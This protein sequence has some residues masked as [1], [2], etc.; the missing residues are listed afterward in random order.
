[1]SEYKD[2]L[3]MS[4]YLASDGITRGD[5]LAA[6]RTAAHFKAKQEAAEK[7]STDAQRFGTAVHMRVLEP[8]LWESTYA[9]G[10][11]D[12]RRNTKV[13]KSFLEELGDGVEAMKPKEVAP[14]FTAAK[15]IRTHPKLTGLF[16][17]GRCIMER[18][19]YWEDE[20][21]GLLCKCRLDIGCAEYSTAYDIK[22]TKDA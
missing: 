17:P 12:D 22:T 1:M 21:T 20:E 9:I 16:D 19:L 14:I 4:T 7:P 3:A 10:P 11:T 6:C 18:S 8:D 5:I 13:W 15:A 2:A